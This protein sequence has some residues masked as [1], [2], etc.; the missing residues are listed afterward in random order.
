MT[1]ARTTPV[2]MLLAASAGQSS[3]TIS[4]LLL[5]A[6][7]R[8]FDSEGFGALA[9]ALEIG[10]MAVAAALLVVADRLGRLRTV[11]LAGAVLTLVGNG[12]SIALSNPTLFILA[13]VVTGLGEGA[14]MA[15]LGSAATRARGSTALFAMFFVTGAGTGVVLTQLLPPLEASWG[16]PGLFAAQTTLAALALLLLAP[17]H[18]LPAFAPVDRLREA[19]RLFPGGAPRVLAGVSLLYVGNVGL[20]TFLERI[21]VSEGMTVAGGARVIGLAA[22]CGIVSGATASTLLDRLPLHRVF[23][24]GFLLMAALSWLATH[25]PGLP[26]FIGAVLAHNATLLWLAPAHL[27]LLA[28]VDPSGRMG[29]LAI[30]PIT[31]GSFAGAVLAATLTPTQGYAV[32]GL[33][34]ATAYVAALVLTGGVALR[35]P[36]RV[37]A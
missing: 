13:R 10:G 32:I 23:A 20:W 19:G 1:A 25:A 22:L 3:V 7:G 26:A 4:P 16:V 9:V 33:V 21:A 12:L 11:F 6:I 34:G 36:R 28:R 17:R 29:A 37:A 2:A 18:S 31:I 15:A 24:V 8:G 30:V 14:L 35:W 27:A 5:G